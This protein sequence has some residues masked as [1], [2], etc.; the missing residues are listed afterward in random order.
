MVRLADP[1]GARI[2]TRGP[3]GFLRVA[4]IAM[5]LVLAQGCS[6]IS[7]PDS[8]P[9]REALGDREVLVMIHSEARF[10]FQPGSAGLAEYGLAPARGAQ[11][12]A[13]SIARDYGL[14][15]ISDWP[16]PSLSM[17]CFLMQ[18]RGPAPVTPTVEVLNNDRRIEWAQPSQSYRVLGHTD[19]YYPLQKAAQS[20]RLDE[21]H[22][23]STGSGVRIAEIDTGIDAHHPDLEGQVSDVQNFVAGGRYVAEVHGTAVAGVI[24]G[25]A[26]NGIGIV[27]VAP[28]SSL[29]GLRACW[30]T[31]GFEG[32]I[33]DSFS[34]A[35]AL[36]FALRR[37]ANIVN[38]SL[39]GPDDRLLSML[40]DK[41]VARGM[42][43]VA[44]ADPERPDGGFPASHTGV[45]AVA[46]DGTQAPLE[47]RAIRAP[48][49]DVLTTTPRASWGFFSGASMA[50]A[51]VTGI[52]A[53]VLARKPGMSHSMVVEALAHGGDDGRMRGAAGGFDGCA[54]FAAVLSVAECKCCS[55]TSVTRRP[56][57]LS[58]GPGTLP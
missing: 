37:E 12:T 3:S 41:A 40:I 24:A 31:D 51:H 38:M 13:A 1:T 16:M 29:L 6:L 47:Q 34:L 54:V 58:E 11:Q 45:V 25:R 36:Q 43:V 49:V 7:P 42:I 9:A 22:Q 17:H 18:V 28:A 15:L 48:G 21:L 27:G 10:R 50:A 8:A 14:E 32:A 19:P 35:K 46:S 57:P 4:L 55:E 30:E 53:L 33:C 23:L 52:V 56:T 2:G 44:A 5:V 20:L 39:T 26:D